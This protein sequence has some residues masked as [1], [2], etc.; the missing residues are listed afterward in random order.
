MTSLFL[1]AWL[2]WSTASLA[3][4]THQSVQ[5]NNDTWTFDIKW[6]DQS[7]QVHQVQFSLDSQ[8]V[9]TD[10]QEPLHFRAR[11]ASQYQAQAIND[12]A[13][14]T[15]GVRVKAKARGKK[16]RIS[17]SGKGINKVRRKLKKAKAVGKTA[18]N[19]YVA[20]NGYT[21]LKG[22]VVPDHLKHIT[23]YADD[24]RPLVSALG[25]PTDD[26]RVFA[27]KALSFTQAI[28]YE[29]RGR[30]PDK[31]RRPL[32]M[33]GRNK[34]DCDSKTVLFLALMHEA[35]PQMPLAVVYIPGHAFGAI[36][37]A[38]DRGELSFRSGGQQWVAV[39]PVGPALYPIG[40]VGRKSKRRL[41][42]K[43][44]KIKSM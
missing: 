5:K 28:P 6:K 30:K 8:T 3:K 13:K 36:G 38:P 21:Y 1:Y 33:I 4:Q 40:K 22:K 42:V 17:A 34:G 31:Y 14:E 2:L 43:G 37:I 16:V 24:L 44:Y 25:G 23:T 18:Q 32:S 41:K 15:K 7:G 39:E 10:I 27:E 29:R 9:K 26:P 20:Q 19:D 11:K 35:Y 12:W